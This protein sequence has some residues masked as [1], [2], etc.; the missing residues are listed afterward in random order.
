[1]KGSVYA[2]YAF[3]L[4]LYRIETDRGQFGLEMLTNCLD[5]SWCNMLKQGATATMEVSVVCATLGG[6]E[7]ENP[8]FFPR[9]GLEQLNIIKLSVQLSS[10][11][12]GVASWWPE[13]TPP[14]CGCFSHVCPG[15]DPP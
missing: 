6:P 10:E 8:I 15:G 7:W 11:L 2:A 5:N 1:M 4:G 12:S 14:G 13:C 9:C 3:L